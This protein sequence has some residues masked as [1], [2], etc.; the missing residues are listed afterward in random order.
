[1]ELNPSTFKIEWSH[2]LISAGMWPISIEDLTQK[3]NETFPVH[4]QVEQVAEWVNELIQL[5]YFE[6]KGHAVQNTLEGIWIAG[7]LPRRACMQPDVWGKFTERRK[8]T[9]RMH[10]APTMLPASTRGYT[11]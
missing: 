4:H 2:A 10:E 7:E 6:E 5:G 11:W 8:H 3:I 9:A 1:M